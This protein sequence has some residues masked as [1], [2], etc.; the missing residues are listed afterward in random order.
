MLHLTQKKSENI[1]K[2]KGLSNKDM[3]PFQKGI[4]MFNYKRVNQKVQMKDDFSKKIKLP[5]QGNQC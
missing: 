2:E 5:E 3:R 4:T 1:K